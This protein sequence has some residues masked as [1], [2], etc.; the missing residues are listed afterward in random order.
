MNHYELLG[1][2]KEASSDQI[3]EAYRRFAK[4]YHPDRFHRLSQQ[5]KAHV[6]ERMLLLN[7]AFHVL[8]DPDERKSYD[9][10]LKSAPASSKKLARYVELDEQILIIQLQRKYEEHAGQIKRV[11]AN[12]SLLS[13]QSLPWIR[14]F[15]VGA[16]LF[17]VIL[18]QQENLNFSDK[19]TPLLL[20]EGL[21][22]VFLALWSTRIGWKTWWQKTHWRFWI[23]FGIFWNWLIF[24]FPQAA[25]LASLGI[26]QNIAGILSIALFLL[27]SWVFMQANDG[28]IQTILAQEAQAQAAENQQLA[29]L[30]REYQTLKQELFGTEPDHDPV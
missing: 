1:I 12:E 28:M 5:G 13:L 20:A 10:T 21:S 23:I 8:S 24:I 6:Q 11:S 27:S 14:A 19:I 4:K 7:E 26:N 16:A 18:P 2:P 30:M 29:Q 17:A 22:F 15:I 25:F 9:Q 3:R